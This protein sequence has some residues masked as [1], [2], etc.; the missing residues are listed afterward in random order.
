MSDSGEDTEENVE[1]QTTPVTAPAVLTGARKFGGFRYT[2]Y[3]SDEEDWVEPATI[4]E[5][6]KLY[7]CGSRF[8]TLDQVPLYED[9]AKEHK[10]KSN[11]FFTCLTFNRC[12]F[13]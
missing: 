5:K 7:R 11:Y 4:E 6:R 13:W 3:E 10:M 12:R 9:Y 8:T 2:S 1:E